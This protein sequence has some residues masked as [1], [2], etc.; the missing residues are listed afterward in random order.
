MVI[1]INLEKDNINSGNKGKLNSRN[2]LFLKGKSLET[3]YSFF[4]PSKS[5]SLLIILQDK[6]FRFYE[7]FKIRMKRSVFNKCVD[8]NSLS[9]FYTTAISQ[10][11]YIRKVRG[12]CRFYFTGNSRQMI[13]KIL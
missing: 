1:S 2:T 5:S 3:F 13:T 4:L 6:R 11:L 8:S 9:V 12:V 10:T 7:H